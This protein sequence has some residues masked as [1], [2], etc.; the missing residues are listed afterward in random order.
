MRIIQHFLADPQTA[1]DFTC[2]SA[3]QTFP[4]ITLP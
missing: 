4:W 3:K 1:P 2:A